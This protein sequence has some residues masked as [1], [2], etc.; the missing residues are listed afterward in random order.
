GVPTGVAVTP[1]MNHGGPCPAS[2][3]SRFT[4]VGTSSIERWL[5]PVC[6]QDCP[7]QLLPEALKDENPLQIFR[8]LNK[9]LTKSTV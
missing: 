5:R 7:R 2:T 4:S 8:S 3:D 1:S 6:F 9:Q